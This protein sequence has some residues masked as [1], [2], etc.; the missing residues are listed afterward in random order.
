MGRTLSPP[1]SL[2]HLQGL[3]LTQPDSV[4]IARSSWLA[5]PPPTQLTPEWQLATRKCSVPAHDDEAMKHTA[6]SNEAHGE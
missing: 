3:S 6:S 4:Y 5:A 1:E 2:H